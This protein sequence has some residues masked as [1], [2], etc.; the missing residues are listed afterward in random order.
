MF[1]QTFKNIDDPTRLSGTLPKSDM[2]TFDI[3]PNF[4]CRIWG[5]TG[6]GKGMIHV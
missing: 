3:N 2:G 4:R 1:E 6:R 5:G